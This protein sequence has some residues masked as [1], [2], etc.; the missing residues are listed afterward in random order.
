MTMTIEKTNDE[1]TI[2][3]SSSVS[4]LSAAVDPWLPFQFG[5][6]MITEVTTVRTSTAAIS[7]GIGTPR[8]A[9]AFY[10]GNLKRPRTEIVPQVTTGGRSSSSPRE[11][12]VTG[13]G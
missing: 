10:S 13:P 5:I 11:A 2:I 9:G 3:T 7:L 1:S 4:I 12:E 6:S 8:I